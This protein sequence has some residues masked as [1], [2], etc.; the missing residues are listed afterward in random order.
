MHIGSEPS[1]TLMRQLAAQ[2]MGDALQGG[3]S[4]EAKS[5]MMKT[6]RSTNT[7]RAVMK[8]LGKRYE[9]YYEAG[10]CSSTLS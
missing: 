8:C 1:G 4:S 2:E 3:C 9:P 10:N 7:A 6:E 5:A